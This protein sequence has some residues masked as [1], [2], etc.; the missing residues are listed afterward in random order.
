MKSRTA[1]KVSFGYGAL[2]H[3]GKAA[4]FTLLATPA[5]ADEVTVLA[6]GDSLT[7]GYGLRQDAGFVPQLQGWLNAR[8][9]DVTVINASVS[10]DTTA[11]GLARMEWSL[12]PDVDAVIVALGG[13]DFLR[14]I[15][16][17]VSRA[18]LA[19]ILD[20]AAREELDVLL[21]GIAASPN[22]GPDFQQAFNAMYPDLSEQ[23]DTLLVTNFF[24]PLLG[25]P[26]S[27]PGALSDLMQAD[28]IH[29]SANGVA[30]IVNSLG[31]IVEDL[32]A[33]TDAP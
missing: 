22:Y 8:G 10:G 7:A 1:A 30:V 15:D 6:L 12:T 2:R 20:I 9:Q 33:R 16:P 13:N 3:W 18:N 4:L 27:D 14:G 31:P 11:G 29:P 28:G 26:I 21:V 23:Y 25:T 24:E 32:I 19:G 5:M 17:E